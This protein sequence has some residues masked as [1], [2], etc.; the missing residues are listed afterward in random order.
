MIYNNADNFRPVDHT[1]DYE[2][3]M[4][5]G[6]FLHYHSNNICIQAKM[7]LGKTLADVTIFVAGWD[8]QEVFVYRVTTLATI[9]ET[10]EDMIKKA[11]EIVRAKAMVE[12]AIF[13]M[14]G[15]IVS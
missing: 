10:R 9:G 12:K 7:G 14:G 4:Q 11:F 5:S 15:G 2:D 6:V 3:S 8:L 1:P 13:E